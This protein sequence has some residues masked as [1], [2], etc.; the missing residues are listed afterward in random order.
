MTQAVHAATHI[1]ILHEAW[2]AAARNGPLVDY[3]VEMQR[4]IS[5]RLLGPCR[6]RWPLYFQLAVPAAAPRAWHG[7]VGSR[8]MATLLPQLEA[9]GLHPRP[10]CVSRPSY[11]VLL[12]P[13]GALWATASDQELVLPLR[14][15]VLP[16]LFNMLTGA[17]RTLCV[18]MPDAPALDLIMP[19]VDV[20]MT[21]SVA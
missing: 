13:R 7:I 16:A 5:A 19:I 20:T 11:L 9:C 6:M 1:A 10:L 17:Y 15:R 12:W 8:L 4:L 18:G 21:D 3:R 14:E 2:A